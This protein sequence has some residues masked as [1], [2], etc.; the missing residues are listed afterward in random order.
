MSASTSTSPGW[1]SELED[2]LLERAADKAL[3]NVEVFSDT[4][5]RAIENNWHHLEWFKISEFHDWCLI[6]AAREHAKT[7]IF[8]KA[9]PLYEI[10]QNP[11][12]RILIISDVHP[13]AQAR[14]TVLRE[15]IAT[16]EAYRARF[17]DVKVVKKK[18][19]EEFWV[20]RDLI[21][22][23]AT[24][25]STYAGGPISGGRYDIVIVDDLVNFLENSTTPGKRKKLKRWW[26][27]EVMSAVAEGGKVWVI[28]TRQHHEDL[29]ETIKQDK[30]FHHRVYPAVDEEDTGYGHLGYAKKN[31]SHGVDPESPDAVC[32][33]PAMHSHEKLMA[34]KLVDLDSY[35]R[36][37]QQLAIPETGL[38]FRR[39][40]VDRALQR[41][42]A[43]GFD[44]HASQYAALDPGYGQ[45]A[46]F[47]AIQERAGD[48]IDLWA[49]H[50]FTQVDDD[51]VSAVVV[52]HC[53]NHNVETLYVDAADPGLIAMIIGKLDALDS[54][55][56]VTP[57]PFNRFKRLSIKASRWLLSGDRVA[58]KAET[59]TVH[60]PG[61][62]TTVPSI[63]RGEVRDYALKD[64]TDDEPIKGSD[65]GPDAW[66]AY[67]SSWIDAWEEATQRAA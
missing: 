52:E 25:T 12:V 60:T 34:K 44:P 27:D 33:W 28:G 35:K 66:T 57:V 36:Q 48:R 16:N 4:K 14:A 49:E 3:F 39:E 8:G 17:P 30:R 2:L 23:E 20:E 54:P 10:G 61:R 37:Q 13:K 18:G 55:T 65:H 22:K 15:H 6:E 31:A 32:L 24:V 40:L 43:V 41:G 38:V 58:W 9:L 56:E 50:S 63:F 29:Y 46:A 19:D 67:A 1:P 42:N 21:L 7:E 59:T 45:R 26:N 53:I 11:N 64:G 5:G 47:L 62:T 51:G